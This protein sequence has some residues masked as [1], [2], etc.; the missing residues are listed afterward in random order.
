MDLMTSLTTFLMPSLQKLKELLISFVLAVTYCMKDILKQSANLGLMKTEESINLLYLFHFYKLGK[1]YHLLKKD[2]IIN[3]TLNM[4]YL[5]R[6]YWRIMELKIHSTRKFL[7]ENFGSFDDVS[8]RLV[9][10]AKVSAQHLDFIKLIR[11]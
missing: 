6:N 9:T 2:F 4:L 11:S 1:C 10:L 7:K 8:K 5:E 3:K